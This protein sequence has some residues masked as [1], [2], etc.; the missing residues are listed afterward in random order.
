MR[1]VRAAVAAGIA[2]A[3]P[4]AIAAPE[5]FNIDPAHTYPGFAVRH[6]GISTQRGRFD[7][8]TGR[9]VLDRASAGGSVEIAIDTTS[10]S[11]GSTQ[12][13]RV[14]RG[15]DFFDVEKHPRITFKSRSVDFERGVL[16]SA[17]GDLTLRGVTRPVTLAIEHFGCTRLPL[18][19]RTTCGADASTT[20][21]RSAF[22]MG[23]YAA[24]IGDDVRITI[25]IEAV[26][27]EPAVEFPPPGG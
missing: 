27:V 2:L 20:V 17:L 25:Q 21:S 11:T 22:G 6:L 9:I 1:L 8:T 4:Q 3:V 12:L 10:I 5:E 19:V 16:R 14:L 26:Q 15:E 18:L 7:K 13:D 24:F 23:S